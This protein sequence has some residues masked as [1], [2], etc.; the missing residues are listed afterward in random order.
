M[1]AG[2]RSTLGI[3]ARGSILAEGAFLMD[4]SRVRVGG[5]FAHGPPGVHVGC[6]G[7]GTSPSAAALP[8]VKADFLQGCG[9][10]VNRGY[11]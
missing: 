10:N 3:G 1:Q 5:L 2:S 9:R 4:V 7:Q 6:T 11:E 8:S